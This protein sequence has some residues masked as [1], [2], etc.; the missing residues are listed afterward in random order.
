ML[1]DSHG[2]QARLENIG[3]CSKVNTVEYNYW[4][5]T[6]RLWGYISWRLFWGFPQDS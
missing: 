5:E 3:C 2:L 1:D 6:Y 4:V